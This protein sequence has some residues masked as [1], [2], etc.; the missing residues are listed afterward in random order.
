MGKEEKDVKLE[1][2]LEKLEIA[3]NELNKS[4]IELDKSIEIYTEAM[5]LVSKGNRRIMQT[6][7]GVLNNKVLIIP[8]LVLIITQVCKTI[9]FSIKNKKLDLFTL[10]TTGG[11]PSSHSALVASLATVIFKTNGVRSTEFA[12]SVI[13]AIIVM[14]DASRNKKSG[15]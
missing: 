13:L 4:D 7:N 5:K 9:Y 2:I 8:F 12:I 14:Y 1:E 6:L 3:N 11:L 15:R 10:L